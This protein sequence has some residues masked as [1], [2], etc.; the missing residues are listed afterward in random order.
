MVLCMATVTTVVSERLGRLAKDDAVQLSRQQAALLASQ[1]GSRLDA[2]L[3]TARGLAQALEGMRAYDPNRAMA[4]EI[5]RRSLEQSPALASVWTVWEPGAFDGRD[6]EFADW[7]GYDS[8][9]RF[10]TSWWRGEGRVELGAMAD[11]TVPGAGDYYLRTQATRQETVLEPA[12]KP[13]GSQERF[14]A[15]L[16]VPVISAKDGQTFLG[17]VGVDLDLSGLV[18]EI[19]GT[20]VGVG[21]YAALISHQG[22]YVAH[23]NAKRLGKPMVESDPWVQPLLGN[24]LRGEGFVTESYSK[25]LDDQTYR[26]AAPVRIG[27]ASTP[28]SVVVT[29]PEREVLA[30]ARHLRNVIVLIGVLALGVILTVVWWIARRIARPLRHVASGL[31]ESS[32]QVASAAAQVAQAGQ[33]LAEGASEQAASLEETSASLEEVSSMTRRNS[34]HALAAKTVAGHA[35]RAA[36]TGA[37]DVARM[38]KAMSGIEASAA[39]VASIVKTIDEIAFQT[40]LLALNAAVEAARAGEAGQGFAIVADEV[41]TLARRSAEAARETAARIQDSITSTQQ[42]LVIG[43]QVA[44]G[45]R[46][47]LARSREV[48]DLVA[49][50]VRASSEQSKGIAQITTTLSGMDKVTQG[51]AARAEESAGSAEELSAQATTM[52]RAV[53]QLFELIEGAATPARKSASPQTEASKASRSSGR[54]NMAKSPEGV[55]GHSA[56]GRSR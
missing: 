52:R 33:S 50:I 20:K 30:E 18:T 42:G 25:T 10:A 29:R 6:A 4:R 11:Y 41:R 38:E 53:A 46:D 9:G 26:I 48:D 31:R 36:E 23:P 21:G 45:L 27:A 15:T 14:V 7:P 55:R 22:R 5:L 19:A 32:L 24:F 37:A 40:N 12:T 2:A 56:A 51:T 34:E 35:R 49:E 16:V 8:T 44:G 47:I 28:W 13:F 54:V 1:A 43:T 39:N 3:A 17:A